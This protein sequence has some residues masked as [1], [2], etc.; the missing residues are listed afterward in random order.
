MT[1]ARS[2]STDPSTS[3]EAARAVESAGI[4]SDQRARCLAEVVRKPGQTAAEIAVAAGLDRYA[5]S[6]RLPE[7]RAAGIVENGPAR[8]CRIKGRLS[9]TWLPRRKKWVAT[10]LGLFEGGATSK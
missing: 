4:A 5:A 2:R 9:L 8:P 6:R 7:L 10:Q 1:E 3:S